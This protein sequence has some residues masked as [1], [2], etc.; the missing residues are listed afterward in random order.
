[1]VSLPEL[2]PT[3][4]SESQSERNAIHSRSTWRTDPLVGSP[5]PGY[6]SADGPPAWHPKLTLYRLLVIF[7]IIGI[8]TAKAVTSCLNL[9]YTSITLEWILSVVLFLVLHV[10]GIYEDAHI[11]RMTWFFEVDYLDYLWD[12]LHRFARIHGPNYRSDEAIEG[13]IS[14]SNHPP[15][16]GYRLLVT[17]TVLTVGMTKSGLVYWDC[18]T[19]N[20]TLEWILELFI[21]TGL[22]WLGLYE[23]SSMKVYPS[24]F[25][26]DYLSKIAYSLS[27][28]FWLSLHLMGMSLAVAWTYAFAFLAHVMY[29]TDVSMP[30]LDP[31]IVHMYKAP[32]LTLP[33]AVCATG[34]AFIFLLLRSLYR[35]SEPLRVFS[36]GR[37][38]AKFFDPVGFHE[39]Y[40]LPTLPSQPR[41]RLFYLKRVL[42]R[43]VIKLPGNYFWFLMYFVTLV[44]CTWLPTGWIAL[45]IVAIDSGWLLGWILASLVVVPAIGF[46]SYLVL[47]MLYAGFHAFLVDMKKDGS[48]DLLE[49]EVLVDK[50]DDSVVQL[51]DGDVPV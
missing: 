25:H 39:K 12:F 1:M 49:V 7:S 13:R 22:Y 47:Y 38:L 6:A 37:Y 10:L 15:M 20:A 19:Q 32:F 44:W 43:Q 46:Y 51:E 40:C 21:V 26:V 3:E 17:S 9:A 30:P 42:I 5:P 23:A 2:S 14:I 16:T 50:K 8:G 36:S 27:T 48:V 4:L 31:F 28:G 24:L 11:R 35:Q 29:L 34:P 33:I 18:Q 41:E 45:L